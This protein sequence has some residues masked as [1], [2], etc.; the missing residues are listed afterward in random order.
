MAASLALLKAGEDFH[1][2]KYLKESERKL[3]LVL[4]S[5]TSKGFFNEINSFNLSKNSLILELLGQYYLNTKDKRILDSATNFI[6]LFLNIDLKLYRKYKKADWIIV[7]GFEIFSNEII[8]GKE[9]LKKALNN[10]DIQHLEYESNFYT[11]LYRLCHANDNSKEDIE[12]IELKTDL[13]TN[14]GLYYARPNKLLNFIR[15]FG[16]HKFLRIR[17]RFL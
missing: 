2:P 9:A 11:E 13:N 8:N 15:P 5:Q 10:F 12:H 14:M 17:Y 4:R 6:N 3:N 16:I 7:D 1:E